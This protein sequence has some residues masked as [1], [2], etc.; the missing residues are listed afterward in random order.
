MNKSRVHITLASDHFYL[1]GRR[2]SWITGSAF[3][4]DGRLILCDNYNYKIKLLNRNFDI[5][6]TLN[7]SYRGYNGLPR[8]FDVAVMNDTL[9]VITLPDKYQIQYIQ[10]N[11]AVP[12]LQREKFVNVERDCYGIDIFNNTIYL[13]CDGP[14]IR[15][16]DMNGHLKNTFTAML[17]YGLYLYIAV[18][19]LSGN[20]YLSSRDVYCLSPN[21]SIL[22]HYNT[23][24][25]LFG[26]SGVLVD[27]LDNPVVGYFKTVEVIKNSDHTYRTLLN[28][29]HDGLINPIYSLAY[30]RTDKTLVIGL[31]WT[32]W[33]QVVKLSD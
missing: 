11:E 12:M 20:L 26:P 28:T 31:G 7:Y 10:L 9:V 21:G 2:V 3:L 5:Q 6:E 25:S 1:F 4:P 24:S 18:S 14:Q 16:L 19:R 32:S 8:I 17:D 15:M 23:N 13:A 33:L 22:F 29:T 30:R 27:D